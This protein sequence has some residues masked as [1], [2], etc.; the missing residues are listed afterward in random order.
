M[1]P[2]IPHIAP[3]GN[4]AWSNKYKMFEGTE[5]G[6]YGMV[7]VFPS[8]A[9]FCVSDAEAL[10]QIASGRSAFKKRIDDYAVLR[11][12]GNNLLVRRICAPAFSDRNNHLVWTT[13]MGF[14][15]NVIESWTP[16]EAVRVRDACEELTLPI[17]LCVIAKAGF[18]R[19]VHWADDAPPPTGHKLTFLYSLKM[20]V[21][22]MIQSRRE[23]QDRNTQRHDLLS[24]LINARDSNDAL[25]E[26]E[27]VGNVMI[28]LIAGHE[29]TGHTL[30]ILLGLLALYPGEQERVG[31][32]IKNL[33][34]GE[35]DLTY[36]DMRQL[37][38]AL[39]VLYETL[40]LYPMVQH[41]PASSR[42]FIFTTGV[43]YNPSYWDYPEEFTPARFIDTDWNRDAFIPFSLGP[44]A[45]IGR[46]FAETTIVAVLAKL[47]SK[48]SVS[49]DESRFESIPGESMLDRQQRFI[50]P[51]T[52]LTLTPAALPLIFI[53]RS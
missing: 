5:A 14:V 49:V 31:Q 17:A 38:Y 42:A 3:G 12:F 9:G 50:N 10:E 30:A 27:L 8:E 25:S 1:L 2:W 11:L 40:R 34:E 48:Y 23:S 35:D 36:D 39:A 45:C 37:P 28:F 44:R 7:S 52:K 51:M 53:P 4:F 47:L 18:G 26:D 16:R 21:R 15:S 22:E 6:I 20:H 24:Q 19:D 13:T 33:R 46:R 41:V 32:E 43:H 29:T